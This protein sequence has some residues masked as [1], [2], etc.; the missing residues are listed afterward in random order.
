[1]L[2]RKLLIIA[3]DIFWIST[4][5]RFFKLYKFDIFTATT[6]S[7]GLTLAEIRRPDCILIDC[8]IVDINGVNLCAAIRAHPIIRKTPIVMM[9]ADPEAEAGSCLKCQADAF[10]L[11]WTPFEKIRMT[12]EVLLRRIHWERGIFEKYDIRIQASNLHVFHGRNVV[13]KL[14]PEQFKMFSLLLEKSPEYVPV[15][16][17]CKKVLN[18]AVSS[19][20]LDAIKM[21]AYRLRKNLG[22]VLGRRIRSRKNW[23]WVYLHPGSRKSTAPGSQLGIAEI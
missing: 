5:I 15:Q 20:K 13:S 18:E 11:K 4:I 10:V 9:S 3:G 6:Y 7:G 21:I 17:I 14:S 8:Q 23:G 22:A 16:E 12:I 1:M 19:S 2:H